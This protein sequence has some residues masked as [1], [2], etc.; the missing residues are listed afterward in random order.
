VRL[1]AGTGGYGDG[2][3]RRDFVYVQDLARINMFFAQLGPYALQAGQSHTTY[4][5]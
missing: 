3:Q 2:E 4:R 1:F 5:A